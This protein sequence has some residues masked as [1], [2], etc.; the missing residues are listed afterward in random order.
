MARTIEASIV[1][2]SLER[3]PAGFL[4]QTT[5]LLATACTHLGDVRRDGW[6]GLKSLNSGVGHDHPHV[7]KLHSV[8]PSVV[9]LSRDLGYKFNKRIV[10]LEIIATYRVRTPR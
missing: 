1:I 8:K 10:N 7:S 3:R 4:I 6:K 9:S 5:E 2:K